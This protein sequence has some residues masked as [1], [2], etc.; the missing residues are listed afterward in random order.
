MYCK[1]GLF[2]FASLCIGLS[3]FQSFQSIEYIIHPERMTKEQYWHVFGKTEISNGF[4]LEIDR[5]STDW[6]DFILSYKQY[7]INHQNKIIYSFK[8]PKTA[9]P[10]QDLSI[11]KFRL[12]DKVPND[13][14]CFLVSFKAMTSDSIKT[15][16][17]RME[18]VSKF[19]CYGWDNYEIS[20]GK[21]QD[22]YTEYFV[23]FNLK[24]IRHSAD[25]MQ[26][27]IDN[28][29]D[30]EVKIKDFEIRAITLIRD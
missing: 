1:I 13:E 22:Q 8:K 3:L 19:N 14:T 15:S 10:M 25:Q 4:R 23:E 21:N 11:A 9:I 12:L 26:I 5:E 16:L 18:T 27:Y 7:G 28:D 2:A 30:V 24:N 20:L 6:T 29:N 17:L